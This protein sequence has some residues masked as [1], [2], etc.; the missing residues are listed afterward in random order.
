MGDE[1]RRRATRVS[2]PCEVEC[3]GVGVGQS[4][5]NP[6]LSDL[7]LTGAFVDSVVTLPPGTRVRLKFPLPSA[8]VTVMAE[9]A[10]AMPQFGMGVRFIDLDPAQRAAIEEVVGPA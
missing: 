4:P 5:L 7:S 9:V 1:D 2:F 6:R 3:T 8:V 10:H